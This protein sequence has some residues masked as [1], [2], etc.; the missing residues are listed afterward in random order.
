[1][2]LKTAIVSSCVMID[3]AHIE[4]FSSTC[5]LRAKCHTKT[6]LELEQACCTQC[7]QIM[8][9]YSTKISECVIE[10]DNG[11][12]IFM[13]EKCIKPNN[14]HI[15]FDVRPI[16]RWTNNNCTVLQMLSGSLTLRLVA[17][18]SQQAFLVSVFLSSNS[19][20]LTQLTTQ[21][22]GEHHENR[23]PLAHVRDHS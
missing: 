9:L 22:R 17:E 3:D 20:P 21:K 18:T 11:I 13:Y 15:H 14:Y 8:C 4:K 10:D 5:A 1:M 7:T 23:P 19:T 16:Y 6:H 2:D 12:N